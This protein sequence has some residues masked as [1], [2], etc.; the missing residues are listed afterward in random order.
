[1]IG[2]VDGQDTDLATVTSMVESV[3]CMCTTVV[4]ILLVQIQDAISRLVIVTKHLVQ[5]DN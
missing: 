5:S 4:S 2:K 1:M 3:K